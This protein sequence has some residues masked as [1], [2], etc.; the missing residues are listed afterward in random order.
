MSDIESLS[1]LKGT[2]ARGATLN[3]F[4][5]VNTDSIWFSAPR[6]NTMF[7]RE[8][9]LFLKDP[10]YEGACCTERQTGSLKTV[11]PFQKAEKLKV[12]SFLLTRLDKSSFAASGKNLLC[13]EH[14]NFFFFFFFS[15]C[16][17]QNSSFYNIAHVKITFGKTNNNRSSF[18]TA[19][20]QTITITYHCMGLSLE[21]LVSPG[22]GLLN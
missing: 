12:Y 17:I 10:F 7:P 4:R 11:S 13:L 2:L 22:I 18:D 16:K 21:V 6:G 14:Y 8:E 9:I 20:S 15:G 1:A 3:M 5:L 19:G